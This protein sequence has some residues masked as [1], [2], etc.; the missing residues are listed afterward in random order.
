[1]S[2]DIVQYQST[3]PGKSGEI[4]S[5]LA[6]KLFLAITMPIMGITF[7]AWGAIHYWARWR[8]G[9]KLGKQDIEHTGRPETTLLGAGRISL[10]AKRR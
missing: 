1:M 4:S 6:L 10:S 2:T 8:A 9:R 7:S 5:L 3:N